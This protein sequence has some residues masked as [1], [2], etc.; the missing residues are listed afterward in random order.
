MSQTDWK[1]AIVPHL[2]AMA[3]FIIISFIFFYP[4]FSG[5]SLRQGDI[6]QWKGMAQES[7]EFQE[8]TGDMTEWTNS[9]F[10]GMPTYQIKPPIGNSNL[11]RPVYASLRYFLPFPASILIVCF[12]GFYMMLIVLGIRPPTAI[13]GAIAFGLMTY[14]FL[15]VEAGHN[16]KFITIA[17]MAP[18]VAGTLLAYRK[19]R[20]LGASIFGLGLALNLYSNHLQITYYLFLMLVIYVLIEFGTAIKEKTTTDFIKSSGVLLAVALLAAA[21]SMSNLLP[22]YEYSKETIRGKSELKGEGKSGGGLDRD[23]ALAWSYGIG[24]TM[25]LLIPRFYGGASA[26]PVSKDSDLYRIIK[27]SSGDNKAPMYW[28]DQPFTGGPIYHGA[29]VCFL[30]LLGLLLVRGSIKW[31]LLSATIFAI[32]LSWGR[33]FPLVTDLFFYYFPLYNKFRVVSMILILAQF[34][35]PFLAALALNHVIEQQKNKGE[36]LKALKISVGVLAGILLFFAFL[37]GSFFR[38]EGAADSNYPPQ[39]AAMLVGERQNMMMMDSLRSLGFIL[40]TAA[41][42][43][44]FLQKKVSE[45]ILAASIGV[46][47]LMDLGLVNS[48][49]LDSK[50]FVSSRKLDQSFQASTADLKILEDKDPDY[51]VL[52]LA[53]NTFNDATTSYHHKSIGGYHGAKL[54]RYQDVIDEHLSKEINTLKTKLQA[55][56][57]DII[58]LFG[59]Q[60]VLNMLNTKYMIYSPAAPPLRNVLAMGHAWFVSNAEV[61]ADANAEIAALNN[62][63]LTQKI[64]VDKRFESQLKSKNLQTDSTAQIVLSE[65]K[66]NYL[67]YD[68]KT[69]TDLFAVF[70]EIYYADGK[71]WQAYIDGKPAEHFRANYLLR[72]MNVP[73]GNHT[74]EFKFESGALSLGKTLSFISSLSLLLLFA[75]GLFWHFKKGE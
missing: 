62:L 59:G 72:A 46:L 5:K 49:Y 65:Y 71:G 48:R 40:V 52:N 14:N 57:P 4:L 11:V 12:A 42:I 24:E 75:G 10:G 44:A 30:F 9:M 54:R 43:W 35:M 47:I 36:I 38:F 22:T 27:Q 60:T 26:E 66:P 69:K 1:K 17:F 20:I 19:K 8:Q 15:I 18:V 13:V 53:V 56:N 31:W 28:G 55:E 70:S 32:V 16:T 68:S 29:I 34:T 21:T 64:I 23:Y 2:G 63:N 67:K 45:L 39:F 73:A 41:L 58:N 3:I 7:L 51:R 37:S 50:D 61:V 6:I 74:I 25:T 33:N